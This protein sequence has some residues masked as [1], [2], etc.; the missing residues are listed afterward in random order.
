MPPTAALSPLAEHRGPDAERLREDVAAA[1]VVVL[2]VIEEPLGS[3][4]D[5]AWVWA[6][7]GGP[8]RAVVVRV[9]LRLPDIGPVRD[10]VSGFFD[11]D[12]HPAV[13]GPGAAASG[14]LP[15][16]SHWQLSVGRL[17]PS[18]PAF[19]VLAHAWPHPDGA[20]L[21]GALALLAP[22][23]DPRPE[24]E[25]LV[26]ALEGLRTETVPRPARIGMARG[27]AIAARLTRAS[28]ISLRPGGSTSEQDPTD[29]LVRRMLV[30]LPPD[31]EQRVLGLLRLEPVVP[32]HVWSDAEVET[33]FPRPVAELLSAPPPAP[34]ASPRTVP[35][36]PT[37]RPEPP[38]RD[39]RVPLL[40]G[41]TV[42]V[43]VLVLLSLALLLG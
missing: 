19:A 39:L 9:G 25:E 8:A 16:G 2:P 18:A 24:L 12:A 14:W 23:V 35:A 11:R 20:G 3:F 42:V 6:P 34:A 38:R 43:L 29:R 30:Q 7:D 10:E 28:G 13:D 15:T 21:G 1:S 37:R 32:G 33:M 40:V 4:L 17:V 41:A 27:M 36:Q 22:G 26:A 31:A 5:G